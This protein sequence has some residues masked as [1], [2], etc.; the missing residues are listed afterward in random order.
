MA[1]VLDRSRSCASTFA[2]SSTFFFVTLPTFVLFGSLEPAPGFLA[3]GRPAAFLRST[4]AGGVFITK[5][6]ERSE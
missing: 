4:L 2:I 3:V 6:N 1:L 5:V